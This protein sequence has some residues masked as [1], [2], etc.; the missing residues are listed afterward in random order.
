MPLLPRPSRSSNSARRRP[1][2]A[3]S[4]AGL[5]AT[6]LLI[7]LAGTASADTGTGT[8][9]LASDLDAL[10]EDPALEEATSGVLVHSLD[11]GDVLYER[12]PGTPLIPASNLKLLTSAAA[13]D[14]LGPDHTF[15]TTVS[16]SEVSVDGVVDGDLH[17]TGTGD[18]SLTS[19]VFNDLAAEVADSGVTEVT[20]DL[21]ADDTYFD[22]ERLNPDWDPAD[23]PYYYAAQISALTVAANEDLDTGVVNATADPGAQS[24]APVDVD[25]DPQA[26][27][28]D[29]S[30]DATTGAPDSE[31][32]LDVSREPDTNQF[33]ATGSLP[34]GGADFS[35]LRTVHEPTDHAA[36]LLAEAL[37]DHGV[38]VHGEVDRAP[39][40]AGAA[41]LAH[42]ESAE[43]SELLVPFMKLS[44]NGHAEILVK[45]MG[46]ETA[47][48]GSWEAGL[49]EMTGA[50]EGLGVE[51]G[52]AELTDGSG[53]AH[54]NQI[55]AETVAS[56]LHTAPGEEWFEA[57][58][59]S[60]PVAGAEDRM[61]GGTLTERMRDTPAQGNVQ[62][63]TGTLTGASA[64]SGYVTGADGEELMF[65]VINNDHTGDAP[66]DVEDAI[67]V[68]LAEFSRDAA[69]RDQP[70][71]STQRVPD[72]G[73]AGE[74]E[75]T[76]AG[77][78]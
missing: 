58:E 48:E 37:A 29:L 27:N 39:E 67:A 54:S 53:L 68:R 5:T 2:L 40:P 63:K 9:D 3:F 33:A 56:V 17:L 12:E 36:H 73:P 16:A 70:N 18:P 59:A 43:L 11:Q 19:D 7:P 51:L 1:T 55:T 25:L 21:L 24:G 35:A 22:T 32:T 69:T 34:A 76:W 6:A 46:Q 28:L 45:A 47:G 15:D 57:W 20:G 42:A 64:L 44:N 26:D 23:E 72:S 71:P 77:T 14:I 38:T 74:L 78:C 10:L 49:T 30:N 41:E 62:A 66:T 8:A 75:C 31:P 13:L 52:S 65:V 4:V 61:E 60:L 50:L